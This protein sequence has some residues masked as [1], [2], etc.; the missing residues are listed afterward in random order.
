MNNPAGRSTNK[1]F[2]ALQREIDAMFREADRRNAEYAAAAARDLHLE[3]LAERF[4][5]EAKDD[6]REE[7][8]GED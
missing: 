6:K 5:A 8:Q 4:M 2:E 1:Q 3:R 7:P